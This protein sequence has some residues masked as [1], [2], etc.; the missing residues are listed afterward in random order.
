MGV[1]KNSGTPKW[2][3][4]NGTPYENGWF[5]G[6]TIFGNIYIYIYTYRS[7]QIIATSHDLNPKGD[8]REIQ[9]GEILFQFGRI[10]LWGWCILLQLDMNMLYLF[11]SGSHEICFV[12]TGVERWFFRWSRIIL[13]RACRRPFFP[14]ARGTSRNIHINYTPKV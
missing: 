11:A 1:S 2:M 8:F 3:V 7:G 10:H 5:G 6:T 12:V 14:A 9:V 13:R 4:C